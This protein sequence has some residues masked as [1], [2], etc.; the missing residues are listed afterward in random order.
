ML[1]F[2]WMDTERHFLCYVW[3]L[4]RIFK[5]QAD[6]CLISTSKSNVRWCHSS[7]SPRG[8]EWDQEMVTGVLSEGSPSSTCIFSSTSEVGEFVDCSVMI[9]HKLTIGCPDSCE[10]L[11][12]GPW[13]LVFSVVCTTW[14]GLYYLLSMTYW[15]SCIAL[16]STS[17]DL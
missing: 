6:I 2:I 17:Y 7:I 5:Y 12:T 9:E 10:L 13:K 3:L 1:A 14:S 4:W 8:L 15:N 16:T 11:E